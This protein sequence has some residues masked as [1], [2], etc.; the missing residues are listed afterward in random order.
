[1]S[2][3]DDVLASITLANL[4]SVAAAVLDRVTEVRKA[5]ELDDAALRTAIGTRVSSLCS[6]AAVATTDQAKASAAATTETA[7]AA[8]VKAS[9]P[10]VT[11]AYLTLV[12]DQVAQ[13][14]TMLADL[15]TWRAQMD[16]GYAL[17]ATATAD[18]ATVVATKL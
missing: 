18:L 1:M 15:Q 10:A 13:I 3:L 6:S 17:A 9:T 14:H 7:A 5:A 12:R 16:A 8:T 4:D 2:A 11:L